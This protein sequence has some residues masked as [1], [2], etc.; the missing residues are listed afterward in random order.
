MKSGLPWEHPTASKTKMP[1]EYPNPQPR[2]QAPLVE[3]RTAQLGLLR[4]AAHA[5]PMTC[6]VALARLAVVLVLGVIALMR[7]PAT[8]IPQVL[9]ALGLAALARTM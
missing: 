4:R 5:T 2:V 3:G 6:L 7:V 9:V 1:G 8:D